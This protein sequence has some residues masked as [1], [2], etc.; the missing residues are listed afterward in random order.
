[1]M[2]ALVLQGG[3][4]KG[5]YQAGALK[6][7]L[8]DLEISYDIICG[9]SVGALNGACIAQ[10][11]GGREITAG[12]ALVD[13][14]L[15][16][17]NS[18]VRK[19]WFFWPFSVPFKPSIFDSRP[20]HALVRK[21]ITGSRIATSGKRFRVS[22]VSL[23]TGQTRTWT[24]L[25]DDVVEGVLASSA[26][27]GGLLPIQT[28]GHW[29]TDGGVRDMTPLNAAINAGALEV[30]VLLLSSPQPSV[31]HEEPRTLNV[32]MRALDLI[33]DEVARNDMERV[34]LYNELIMHGAHTD[35]NIIDL[36]VLTPDQ[37]LGS[38][39]DFDPERI[40][41]NINAGYEAAKRISWS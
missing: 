3:G 41:T 32:L 33:L 1:M 19:K 8:C 30:D 38:T 11:E 15:S 9:I 25:D 34:K 27:P 24:E 35:K 13:L 28:P 31:S 2:R 37:P 18:R 29:W 12:K 22:A 5:A 36:R 7:L 23:T 4:A 6:H 14:W 17:D 20:L 10:F 39:L 40:R 16:I 21:R 26:F